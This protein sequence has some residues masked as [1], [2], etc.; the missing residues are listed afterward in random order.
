MAVTCNSFA[1][2]TV[3]TTQQTVACLGPKVVNLIDNELLPEQFLLLVIDALQRLAAGGGSPA[4]LADAEACDVSET[5]R[6][7]ACADHDLTPVFEVNTP[8]LQA[9]ILWMLNEGLCAV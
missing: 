6:L 1:D 7:A 8:Q 5:L 2:N 9:I 3:G 4:S